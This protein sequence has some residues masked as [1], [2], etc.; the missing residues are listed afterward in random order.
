[1]KFVKLVVILVLSAVIVVFAMVNSHDISVNFPLSEYSFE[2]PLYI[3][4]FITLILGVII[5]MILS[6]FLRVSSGVKNRKLNKRIN[7]LEK[8]I[9]TLKAGNK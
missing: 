8:E 7:G 3:L 9:E 4:F 5:S 2:L 6:L 1:M